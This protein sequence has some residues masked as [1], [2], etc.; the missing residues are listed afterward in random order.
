V[1]RL[2]RYFWINSADLFL[3]MFLYPA[4][5]RRFHCL[6]CP[7]D[8]GDIYLRYRSMT[9]VYYWSVTGVKPVEI[10]TEIIDYNSH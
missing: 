4:V 1:F 2:I 8:A 6:R 9:V 3:K 7:K 5:P 10:S